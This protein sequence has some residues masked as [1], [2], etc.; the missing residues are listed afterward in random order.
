MSKADE[1]YFT[2]ALSPKVVALAFIKS[3]V[4]PLLVLAGRM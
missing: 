1:G 2:M 4:V 3:A